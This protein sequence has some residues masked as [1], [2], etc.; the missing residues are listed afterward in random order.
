M[1]T[2]LPSKIGKYDV[3]GLI[4]RGGRGVVFDALDPDLNRRVAIKMIAQ[5]F[6]ADGENWKRFSAHAESLGALQ[7]ANIVKVYDAGLEEGYPYVVMEYADGESLERA[8]KGSRNFTLPEKLSIVAQVCTG[9]A[10]AHRHGIPH[11]DIK[12]GNIILCRDGGVKITDLGISNAVSETVIRN[13]ELNDT[14]N[15]IAPEYAGAGVSDYRAD[16][17]STGVVLYQLLSNHLPFEGDNPEATIHNILHEPRPALSR[18]GTKYRPEIESVLE[19]VVER[20][21]NR[22]WIER[23]PKI[24]RIGI[25]CGGFRIRPAAPGWPARRTIGNPQDSGTATAGEDGAF[26][27]TTIVIVTAVDSGHGNQSAIRL[28]G[29]VER[30][31]HQFESS[32]PLFN[33]W[34]QAERALA[35][36]R[37]EEA[38]EQAEKALALAPE[39][40]DLQQLRETI[41]VE[42]ARTEKLK[43]ILSTAL[44]GQA[45][46]NLDAARKAAE[47]AV[48]VAPNNTEAKALYQLISLQAL[49]LAR[50]RQIENSLQSARQ[51]IS[52][53]NFGAAIGILRGAEELDPNAPGV[54]SLIQLAVSGQQQESRRQESERHQQAVESQKSAELA[55]AA[56]AL[57]R[58]DYDDAIQIL[59][60][61]AKGI[62]QDAEIH[63]LLDRAHSERATAVEAVLRKADEEA[64]LNQSKII[65]RTALQKLP[66]EERLKEKLVEV[67][68]F[69]QMVCKA[70][71]E[72]RRL[73]DAGQ[74][75]S[76]LAK[77]EMVRVLHPRHPDLKETPKRIRT[78]Q[79]R[80]RDVSKQA[81]IDRIESA[82]SKSDFSEVRELVDES[83]LQFAWDSELMDLQE[84]AEAGIRQRAKAQKLVAKAQKLLSKQKWE[85]AGERFVHAFHA[86]P[87]DGW[88]GSK[89][90]KGCRLHPAT[91]CRRT[92]RPA[93]LSCGNS[94]SWRESPQARTK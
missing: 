53:R 37:F 29:D 55:H 80:S 81:W 33:L 46:G 19:S 40:L 23:W 91:R 83:L 24:R 7:H 66:T 41:R 84:R 34:V 71:V 35:E 67:D 52:S 13:A 38:G 16:F 85:A 26:V 27:G 74:Y 32:M 90:L 62:D 54:Q 79:E 58:G 50:Q 72:A 12:P 75:E 36:E 8:M 4:R 31:I 5:T 56:E 44:S 25:K 42:A 73:E 39:D 93:S 92:A 49:E 68:H 17:F 86:A 82:L 78:L 70:I 9:L 10:Y 51:E 57:R 11:H 14:L 60:E 64:D 45:V 69:D 65:L 21:W 1:T 30:G 88:Y 3:V 94:L 43:T 20:P 6:L 76:A 59:E 15:Y 89:W 63:Q 22:S 2:Q 18:F 61:L 47:E 77:W 87:G 48:E 28:L